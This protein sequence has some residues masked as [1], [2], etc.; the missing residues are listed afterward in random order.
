MLDAFLYRSST[1]IHV[2]VL[3]TL[4]TAVVLP[5]GN[6]T[7]A[8]TASVQPTITQQDCSFHQCAIEMEERASTSESRTGR[9]SC[10]T[11]SVMMRFAEKC[12]SSADDVRASACWHGV[13]DKEMTREGKELS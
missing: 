1:E 3:E 12:S 9:F 4:F 13:G 5:R 10:D 2:S 11:R 7:K 8:D 6:Q